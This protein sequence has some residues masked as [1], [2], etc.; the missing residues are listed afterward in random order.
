M[1]NFTIN[2][3]FK[4]C[5]VSKTGRKKACNIASSI[6]ALS[7]MVSD[8]LV[9]I[10][11][12]IDGHLWWPSILASIIICGNIAT[13]FI[14]KQIIQ[15]TIFDIWWVALSFLF[16]I[17][18]VMLTIKFFEPL[19]FAAPKVS[20]SP[21]GALSSDE[22]KTRKK[23]KKKTRGNETINM[24]LNPKSAIFVQGL[25][26]YAK[27]LEILFESMPCGAIQLYVILYLN[28]YDFII[29][30]SL[31][32][33]ILRIG[34]GIE[35]HMFAVVL[36]FVVSLREPAV[37]LPENHS[38]FVAD[39][40]PQ[41]IRDN[42]APSASPASIIAP[43]SSSPASNY[44]NNNSNINPASSVI[45][46]NITDIEYDP[47]TDVNYN[48][49]SKSANSDAKPLPRN[50]L[51][52]ISSVSNDTG[53]DDNVGKLEDYISN[54][55]GN[56]STVTPL[57]PGR[58]SIAGANSN[59]NN[60]NN[61]NTI[62]TIVPI[63][64]A[65]SSGNSG[66]SN[67]TN[68]YVSNKLSTPNNI[69]NNSYSTN[70]TI[71]GNI[72]NYNYSPSTIQMTTP[73]TNTNGTINIQRKT[74]GRNLRILR[75]MDESDEMNNIFSRIL[76]KAYFA[77]DFIVR[78]LSKCV[79]VLV[80]QS[81]SFEQE[82]MTYFYTSLFLIAIYLY[83]CIKSY[84]KFGKTRVLIKSVWSMV[85]AFGEFIP[86]DPNGVVNA[87]YVRR[88]IMTAKWWLL[89]SYCLSMC[90]FAVWVFLNVFENGKYIDSDDDG[91]GGSGPNIMGKMR[92]WSWVAVY[93]VC[94]CVTLMTL[95]L[96]FWESLVVKIKT[97]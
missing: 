74:F 32:L 47:D 67:T 4:L 69:T 5:G 2:I 52:G 75:K 80:L 22:K 54:A 18:S 33:S 68:L 17:G 70:S 76:I 37:A 31:I 27:V 83:Y 48:G 16:D 87:Y 58:A 95:S 61:T 97:C 35:N 21:G 43:H 91:G 8:I 15:H 71:G 28:K 3:L 60:N 49:T 62:T 53:N 13:Y 81:L 63:G 90:L 93:G 29:T 44:Y 6:L 20:R 40:S 26:A 25:Y 41:R 94:Q 42:M 23:K 45:V 84:Y 24:G 14:Y 34:N 77:S 88:R 51:K 66:S 56:V 85:C 89:F 12:Y 10:V 30:G 64:A 19:A 92:L 65:A 7:D 55:H 50:E 78:V 57:N 11:W 1:L 79:F 59:N 38:R 39:K 82:W 36:A 73:S 72:N 86:L 9:V 96:D 46:R